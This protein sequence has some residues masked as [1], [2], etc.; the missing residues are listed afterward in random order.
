MLVSISYIEIWSGVIRFM[1]EDENPFRPVRT[2]VSLI[3]VLTLFY[4]IGECLNL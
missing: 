3:P 4:L 2:T 1:Y